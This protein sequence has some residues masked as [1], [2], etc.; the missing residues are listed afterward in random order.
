MPSK[1]AKEVQAQRAVEDA[2]RRKVGAAPSGIQAGKE[3]S[4]AHRTAMEDAR[5]SPP[6]P[7]LA[8]APQDVMPRI[9]KTPEQ[10]EQAKQHAEVIERLDAINASLHQLISLLS[11]AK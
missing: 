4:S 5:V 7:N 2:A 6:S 1:N 9:V 3:Q 8:S 11:Q 10:A